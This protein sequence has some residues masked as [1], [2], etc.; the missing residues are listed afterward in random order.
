[1]QTTIVS[2]KTPSSRSCC[3]DLVG[4]VGEA[5]AAERMVGRA[6]RDARTACRR[7][8]RPR[9]SA[10]SQLAWMPM[11]N[12]DGSSRTSA[13]MMRDSRMLPTRSLTGVR[14]VDP[15]LL[16]QHGLEARAS[17]RPRRPGGCGWTGS[18][19]WRPACRRPGRARPGRCT[20]ACGSCCR[21]RRARCCSPRAWPRCCAP[22]RCAVSR[23]SGW[24]GLGPNGQRVAL[25]AVESARVMGSPGGSGVAGSGWWTDGVEGEPVLAGGLGGR[26]GVAG[27][28]RAR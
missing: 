26:L 21:R 8:P 10:C 22:P 11:S 27:G 16:H 14:P 23:S 15:L 20:R 7:P 18:R 5:E 17:R 13:P 12:P 1:M 3:C 6:R 4:P 9:R 19:R 2:K 28:R 25:E 24:T